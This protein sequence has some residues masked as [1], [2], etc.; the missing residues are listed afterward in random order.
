MTT[1][2]TSI[3]QAEIWAPPLRGLTIGVTLVVV[4]TAFEALAVAT[5]MPVLARELGGLAYY[6]WAFSAFLLAN[7]IGITV[8]GSESERF[9]RARSFKAG[10]ALF[11][12]GLALSGIA[13]TMPVIVVGR[14]LQ[15]FGAGL[16]YTLSYSAVA[17]AYAVSL[18][19]RMLAILSSAWVIPGLVGPGIAGL[20][21]EHLSWR[22]VFLG[23]L[24]MPLLAAKLVLP[25]LA[26]FA[27]SSRAAGG[28]RIGLAFRL[29][30]GSGTALVGVGASSWQLALPLTA[31]GT[32][33]AAHALRQLLPPG[34]LSARA[35]LPAAI[36]S[37]GLINF[38][39]FG[40]EAFVPLALT[41]VRHAPVLIGSVALTAAAL[42]W[43][44]GAWLTV[45]FAGRVRRRV[46]VRRGLASLAAGLIAT[47]A[48]LSSSVPAWCA[49]IAWG[50]AGLGMG[51]AFTATSASILE[52]AV[53][54][55]EGVASASLQLAQVLGA[56]LSTGIGGALIAA[57]FA[58]DPPRVGI[59]VVDVLMIAVVA[60]AL[61]V[62]SSI[63][64]A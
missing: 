59:A 42:S 61:W 18:Q 7:I 38:A 31:L 54:G 55:E 4:A 5:I 35:G 51:L 52:S 14:V 9:G 53:P 23:L 11:C 28:G 40:T 29:G 50:I 41:H 62:A 58:G 49:V 30:L 37:M 8:G 60:L 25:A 33:V 47:L 21:A 6:G 15:G 26:G 19:P 57:P 10:T 12:G 34:T 13:P 27:P 22:W 48:L 39:F 3:E 2:S 44:A 46:I 43:T 36:A 32:V 17:R 64:D 24:P 45:R 63:P 20:V 56:A 1:E 16:V